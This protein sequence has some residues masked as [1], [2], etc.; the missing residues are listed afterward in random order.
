M[1]T[2]PPVIS[3]SPAARALLTEAHGSWTNDP[4][5]FSY[6]REKCNASGEGCS[7]I[8]YA[9]SQAYLVPASD[10]GHTIRVQEVASNAAGASRPAISAPTAVVGLPAATALSRAIVPTGHG[11]TLEALL[12][13]GSYAVI[14]DAPGAGHLAISWYLDPRRATS[15]RKLIARLSVNLHR[16]GATRITITLPRRDRRLLEPYRAATVTATGGFTERGQR[17]TTVTRRFTLRR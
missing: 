14:F 15:Q 11:A 2:S 4:T 10:A 7:A 1:S 6:Q 12:R 3:G 5:A 9:T 13:Q 17:A 16:A 8:P